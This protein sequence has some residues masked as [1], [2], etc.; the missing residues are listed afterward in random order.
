MD[1]KNIVAFIKAGYTASEILEI[2]KE[3]RSAYIELLQAGVDKASIS[4]YINMMAEPDNKE[5]EGGKDPEENNAGNEGS[6]SDN[7]DYKAMYEAEKAKNQHANVHA[8]NSDQEPTK[9]AYDILTNF[10]SDI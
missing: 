2:P 5:Q 8:D 9:T 7:V 10:L 3:Q 1:I 6:D 4:D